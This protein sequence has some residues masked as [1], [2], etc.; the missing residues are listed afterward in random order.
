MPQ[1]N[2]G[3][4]A[5]TE[6]F[7]HLFSLERLDTTVIGTT[8]FGAARHQNGRVAREPL[9]YAIGQE[10]VSVCGARKKKRDDDN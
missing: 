2:P 9:V 10:C 1:R 8:L 4:K 6:I 3:A 7:S 5:G